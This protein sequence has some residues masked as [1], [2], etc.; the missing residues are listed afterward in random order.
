M[1]GFRPVLYILT[2]AVGAMALSAHAA[3]VTTPVPFT[4]QAPF[5]S[6]ASPWQD[7]CE[8]ASLVMAVHFRWGMPLTPEIANLE[9]QIIKQFEEIVF[10]RY[11]DTSIEESALVLQ[12]LFGFDGVRTRLVA[13]MDD[14]RAQLALGHLVIVPVSGRML[15]NPYFTSPGPRYHM[16]VVRGF[17]DAT[18]EFITN[19]PG[20]R[21]GNGFRY[22]YST[23]FTALHDWNNGNV[24]QGE[25]RIMVV[26]KRV[27]K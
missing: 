8:E 6:W 12:K 20:T 19:D 9:M 5:G 21:R 25:K 15:G 16:L 23:L 13:S 4:S 7:F 18:K 22:R 14:I 2:I 3:S 10:K 11:K 17:D 1:Q 27:T 24:E 26:E